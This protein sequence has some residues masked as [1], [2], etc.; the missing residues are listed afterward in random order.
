MAMYEV[1]SGSGMSR[2]H[3]GKPVDFMRTNVEGLELYA[4]VDPFK[5]NETTVTRMLQSEILRQAIMGRGGLQGNT[6]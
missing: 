2:N 6:F 4:E 3:P 1:E 5:H